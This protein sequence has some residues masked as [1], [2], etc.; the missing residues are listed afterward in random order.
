[1]FLHPLMVHSAGVNSAAHGAG[2]VRIATVME[3]QLQR[4]EGERTMWWTLTDAT[5]AV[6]R[7]ESDS[8]DS[9]TNT[10]VRVDRSFAAAMDGRKAEDEAESEVRSPPL[11]LGHVPPCSCGLC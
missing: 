9:T 2:T 11:L 8:P 3:W 7:G 4:P 5:R 1:M 6:A 10:R